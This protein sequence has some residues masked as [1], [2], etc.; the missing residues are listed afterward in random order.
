MLRELIPRLARE[1][2]IE[3]DLNE[4]AYT[5]HV[6]VAMTSSVLPSTLVYDQR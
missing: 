5:N 3:L 1:E 4:V 6:A 2:R